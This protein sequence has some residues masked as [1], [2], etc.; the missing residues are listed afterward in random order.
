[1]TLASNAGPIL[2][3]VHRQLYST[4]F[5]IALISLPIVVSS[6]TLADSTFC[7]L[8]LAE[9]GESE[10]GEEGESEEKEAKE[11]SEKYTFA[12]QN[13]WSSLD[14]S[15]LEFTKHTGLTSHDC[16]DVVTPPPQKHRFVSF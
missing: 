12:Y 11:N 14:V 8:E 13:G 9:N 15:A 3:T 1:M 16:L 10:P 4:F 6:I 2:A 7:P 5:L